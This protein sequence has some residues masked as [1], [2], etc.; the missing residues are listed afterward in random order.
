[1]VYHIAHGVAVTEYLVT[2]WFRPQFKS[3]PYV[4]S[5]GKHST[6]YILPSYV[7]GDEFIG[8]VLVLVG[9]A[10]RSTAMIHAATNFSHAVAFRKLDTHQLVTDGVYA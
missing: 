2:M 5:V 4:S 7:N 10:L 3:L 6:Y 8:M 1:M 9:Q